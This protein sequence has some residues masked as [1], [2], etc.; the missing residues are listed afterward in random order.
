MCFKNQMGEE[1]EGF[2]GLTL[3]LDGYFT[4]TY[5]SLIVLNNFKP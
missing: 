3:F 2:V 5:L 1:G 4:L